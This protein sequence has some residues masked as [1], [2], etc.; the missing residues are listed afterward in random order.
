MI[1]SGVQIMRQFAERATS[2]WEIDRQTSGDL[3]RPFCIVVL[4]NK[5]K[6]GEPHVKA[7]STD[8]QSMQAY[9][10][11]MQKDLGELTNEEFVEK[12]SLGSWA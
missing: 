8:F 9:A 4:R 6:S 2:C 11:G 5:K 1:E 3:R 7:S 12:Y 10:D